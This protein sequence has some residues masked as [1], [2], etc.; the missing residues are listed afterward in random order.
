MP[1]EAKPS[2]NRA[3]WWIVK[4]IRVAFTLIELLV[5]I[6]IIAVLIGLLLPAVQKVREAAARASDLNHIR[7]CGLATHNANDANGQMPALIGVRFS[8]SSGGSS[9]QLL[10]SFWVL[11]T[12]YLEQDVS[13]NNVS[14]TNDAWAKVPIK[15]YTSRKDP[16]T[17]N[18]IGVDGLPVGNYAANGQVFGLPILGVGGVADAG[19]NLNHSFPDGTS[20]VILFTTKAGKC[21]S[22]GSVYA[23]ID[24]AGYTNSTTFGAFFGHK[25][26]DA[27]GIGTPFQITPKPNVCDPD[28]PQSFYS[29]GILVG[30]ADG[31]ARNV[32]SSISPLTWRMV[33]LPNDG[34]VLGSDW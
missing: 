34:A 21:G 23:S 20:N 25:L 10:I 2:Q 6:A 19:A 13:F 7:Q 3:E 29:S 15:M 18:G 32:R 26:P 31:S 4:K 5:V 24:L 33:L 30:V 27:S 28:L 12:P 16:T 22:G 11:L 14:T 8:A 17:S 9:A 1:S